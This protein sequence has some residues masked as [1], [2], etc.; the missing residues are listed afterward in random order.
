[1][2]AAR[3]AVR[4]DLFREVIGIAFAAP[5]HLGLLGSQDPSHGA[6]E[7]A[8]LAGLL[9]ELRAALR[10]ER[11][12]ARLTVVFGDTPFRRDPA[13]LFEPLQGEVERA[14]VDEEDLLG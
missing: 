3:H 9:G 14:V 6:R 2:R 5:E 7:A 10:G 12:E 8:P 1:M 13:L 11:V 4:S